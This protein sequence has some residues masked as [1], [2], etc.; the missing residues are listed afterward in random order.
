MSFSNSTGRF[1]LNKVIVRKPIQFP[2]GTSQETAYNDIVLEASSTISSP[3]ALSDAVPV[4]IF[5][6][7]LSPGLYQMSGFVAVNTDA[8]LTD[9]SVIV[10]NDDFSWRSSA[11]E[12]TTG[13]NQTFRIPISFTWGE[14]GLGTELTLT[15]RFTGGGANIAT[16]TLRAYRL[17]KD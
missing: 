10:D 8:V 7:T 13:N 3:I 9:F 15:A 11:Q 16:G 2:D 12:T 5:P 4:S 1:D 6:L 17:R 14:S